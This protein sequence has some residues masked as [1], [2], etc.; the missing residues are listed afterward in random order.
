[1]KFSLSSLISILALVAPAATAQGDDTAQTEER[2]RPGAI[3]DIEEARKLLPSHLEVLEARQQLQELVFDAPDD[4]IVPYL[5]AIEGVHEFR[6]KVRE[7]IAEAQ[8]MIREAEKQREQP[9]VRLLA[10][11]T[12]A[13]D[14]RERSPD[15]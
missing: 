1:M 7:G 13:N 10:T 5:R 14:D 6:A 9:K 2:E 11:G 8:E 12:A 3:M 15:P 4:L